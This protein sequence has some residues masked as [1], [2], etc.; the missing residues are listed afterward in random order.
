VRA[1]RRIELLG[2][3]DPEAGDDVAVAVALLEPHVPEHPLA[4]RHEDRHPSLRVGI[5]W[6]TREVLGEL[7]DALGEDGDLHLA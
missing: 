3:A 1:H 4:L 6:M 7:L 5:F 2:G